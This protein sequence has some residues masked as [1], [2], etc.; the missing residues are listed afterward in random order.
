MIFCH[1]QATLRNRRIKYRLTMDTSTTTM[2]PVHQPSLTLP[3]YTP[4]GKVKYGATLRRSTEGRFVIIRLRVSCSHCTLHGL[5]DIFPKFSK[6]L[7]LTGK[8]ARYF[9]SR[10]LLVWREKLGNACIRWLNYKQS[11]ALYSLHTY[12]C[13]APSTFGALLTLHCFFH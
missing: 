8:M 9:L 5:W 10:L 1:V 2:A 11:S 4:E 6:I 13:E 3:C 7:I 12:D